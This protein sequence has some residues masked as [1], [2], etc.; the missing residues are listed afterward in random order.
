MRLT[1]YIFSISFSE[2]F[3]SCEN[4]PDIEDMKEEVEVRNQDGSVRKASYFDKKTNEKLLEREYYPEK[5]PFREWSYKAGLKNGEARSF[6][7]N[8]IIWSL[9]TYKNDT[10]DGP[11][12]TWQENGKPFIEGQFEMGEKSGVWKFYGKGGEVV[13]TFDYESMDSTMMRN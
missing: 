11:Y 9:N 10:L 12:K 4:T 3:F 2:L 5:K 13:R 7:E 1:F 8:G 6:R